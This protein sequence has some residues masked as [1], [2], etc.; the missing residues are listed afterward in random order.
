MTKLEKQN[1][2]ISHNFAWYSREFASMLG[3]VIALLIIPLFAQGARLY[4][5]P[6][7][8]QYHRGDTFIAEV[9]LD[10]ES[11]EINTA[12]VN[13]TFPQNLLEVVDF[14]EGNSIL[15]L[16]PEEPSF[17]NQNGQISF[18]GGVP[19]GYQGTDGLLGKIIFRVVSRSVSR[20]FAEVVFQDDSQVLLN[21]GFGTPAKL[22]FREGNYE[23]V[24]R[25]KELPVI[26][27]KTHPDQNKWYKS[28]TLY[29][30]WDLVEGAEYSYLLSRDSLAEPDETP[31]KPEGELIWMGDMKYDFEKEGDGIY[32][33]SLRQKLLAEDWQKEVSRFRV[34]IDATPPEE[35]KPEIGQDPAVFEGKY[36][37]AFFTTDVGTGVDYYEVLE[38]DERGYQ[39]GT[40]LKAE[41]KRAESPYL[42]EDQSLQSIIKVRAV[43]KAGNERVA[44]I[45][46]PYKI[47]WK[48]I[49]L[50]II[51][52][53]MIGVVIWQLI[54][55]FRK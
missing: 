19:N 6:A 15:T 44:E 49:L 23:I 37:I 39:R 36:F 32:Y 13:L 29:L 24:E 2:I 53:A 28:T 1:K 3:L 27:S 21:D 52:V 35:F 33:F 40:T 55:R 41:W 34:M 30:H 16:W 10:T 20:G 48:E 17:S 12:Q 11:E 31:D 14:S 47:T 9:K 46:P 51:I 8:G 7:N 25:P 42:L 5:E 50:G 26:S 43:D 38:A 22:S 45:I 18:S 54:R 4:L